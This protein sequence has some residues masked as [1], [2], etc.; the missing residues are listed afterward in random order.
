MSKI[1]NKKDMLDI[2]IDKP[3]TWKDIK[4]F[5]LEDD[6]EISIGWE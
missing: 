6:D 1:K 3:I 4:D 2:Q 5:Q